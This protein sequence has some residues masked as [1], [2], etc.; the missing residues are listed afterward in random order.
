MKRRELMLLLGGSA[1]P[2]PLT[3]RAQQASEVYR[4]GFLWDSPAV[5][6]EAIEAFRDGL[7]ELGWID[8]R[9]ITIEY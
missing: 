6:A 4:I 9:N 5:F 2:W 1:V 3:A 7:R 8:G